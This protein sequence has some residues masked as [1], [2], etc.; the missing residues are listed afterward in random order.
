[1]TVIWICVW[2]GKFLFK[3]YCLLPLLIMLH[4]LSLLKNINNTQRWIGL[5]ITCVWIHFTSMYVCFARA[6][7][8]AVDTNHWLLSEYKR[9]AAAPSVLFCTICF[10]F[11]HNMYATMLIHTY[12][13]ST[14][15]WRDRDTRYHKK[16]NNNNKNWTIVGKQHD[17][18][19]SDGW[20]WC[21]VHWRPHSI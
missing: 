3:W 8:G 14:H 1:M 18:A 12:V 17:W 19:N 9:I 11:A 4:I 16:R 7:V 15:G 5:T 2:V 21:S 13:Q 6:C 20:N 10:F